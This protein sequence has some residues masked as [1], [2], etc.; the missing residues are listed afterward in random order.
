MTIVSTRIT[1]SEIGSSE[2]QVPAI[3]RERAVDALC[4]F[5]ELTFEPE[6]THRAITRLI[7]RGYLCEI[8]GSLRATTSTEER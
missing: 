3:S 4:T 1:D 2:D 6:C 5:N 7:E 8:D